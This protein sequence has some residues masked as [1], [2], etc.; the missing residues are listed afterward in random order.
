M[1]RSGTVT[2]EIARSAVGKATRVAQVVPEAS[3]FVQS[4]WAALNA[5]DKDQRSTGRRHAPPPQG[6]ASKWIDQ[7]PT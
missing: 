7:G 2:V 1:Q 6:D 5:A 3:P 4:L